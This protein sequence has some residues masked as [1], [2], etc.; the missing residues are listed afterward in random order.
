MKVL[1]VGLAGEHKG[2]GSRYG[3]RGLEAADT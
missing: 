3:F 1:R 2:R